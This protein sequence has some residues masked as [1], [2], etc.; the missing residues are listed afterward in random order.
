MMKN[1]QNIL[2]KKIFYLND[3]HIFYHQVNNI[4][5]D[6]SSITKEERLKQKNR[7][8]FYWNVLGKEPIVPNTQKL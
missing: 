8:G 2:L 1:I 4:K 6:L 3:I 7:L 5:L